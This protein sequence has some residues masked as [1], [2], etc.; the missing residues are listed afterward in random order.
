MSRESF[1][2]VHRE[3]LDAEDKFSEGVGL[4]VEELRR[5]AQRSQPLPTPGFQH[6]RARR[7]F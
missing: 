7:R 5:A 2:Q 1:L 4:I 6:Y 3:G